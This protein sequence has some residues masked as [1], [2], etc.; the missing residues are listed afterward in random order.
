MIADLRF[1]FRMLAKNPGFAFVCVLT[2]A[3]G[4]GSATVVFSAIKTMLLNPLPMVR[5]QSRLV[6]ISE[7]AYAR[8]HADM[9]LAYEDFVDIRN[10]MTAFE[11]VWSHSDRTIVITATQAEPERLLGNEISE[12]AFQHLGLEPLHGRT[13]TPADHVFGAP[14]VAVLGHGVWRR[15]FGGDPH[16]VG[17]TVHLNGQPTVLIGVMPKGVVYPR[18]SDI[19]VPQ[20]Q[21]PAR[22]SMR[23][24]YHLIGNAKLKPGVS[25][26]QAQAEADGIMAS[27][28]REFPLTN[29]GIGLHIQSLSRQVAGDAQYLLILLFGA[30]MFVFLISCLNVANLVLARTASRSREFALRQALGAERNRLIRQLLTES[31]L[32]AFL[33]G[34]G[35]LLVSLWGMDLVLALIP[36]ETP[37]WLRFDV[38]ASIFS[39]V[40]LLSGLSA[41][42]FGLA[43]AF[44]ATHPGL[45]HEIKEGGRTGAIATVRRSRLHHGLVVAEIA[46]AL[47][48][49]VGA[50]LMM[51][52]LLHL[53]KVD[54]GFDASRVFTFRTG[55]PVGLH[56][57][58]DEVRR[59]FSSLVE[60]LEALPGVEAASATSTLPG[61]D[62]NFSAFLLDGMTEPMRLSDAVIAYHRLVMDR[63]FET[64]KIPL[65][66]GRYFDGR[67]SPHTPRVALVDEIFAREHFGTPENAIGK[68]IRTVDQ[69]DEPLVPVEIVGV[70]GNIRHR[71]D[72]SDQKPT[73]YVT[74]SQNSVNFMSV[75]MR[76]AS[77]PVDY[78]ALAQSEVLK[79]NPDIPIYY[80]FPLDQVLLQTV[81][82]RQFF[83]HLFSLFAAIAL[84][85]ACIGIY[86][87]MSYSVNQ[88]TREI[89][90]RMALGAQPREVISMV[91]RQGIRLVALGLVSG[92]VCAAVAV[93]FFSGYLYGVSPHDPPTFVLVPIA[94]AIIAL[95]ACYLPSRRA[96]RI[97]PMVALRAE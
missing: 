69:M 15:R 33:G 30:V 3:V 72:R 36:V 88:R 37:F 21:D 89:G 1:A 45:I 95:I 70:V 29:E 55:F 61:V 77:D 34:I 75:I 57:E 60:R 39:F 7:T 17:R 86:G 26:K 59:F 24:S 12:G 64:M 96:T 25:L 73:C 43:P 52:S 11:G 23:G 76:T 66:A 93:R 62:M 54:P 19:W 32:L 2:L 83:S 18:A 91:L 44:R 71:L 58:K 65:L 47:V 28:A 92:L 78:A 63:Y 74:H 85:L 56:P 4:I 20:R 68:R 87:V 82:T 16:V 13:F 22:G 94:L 79:L 81:W 14:H 38:D 42:I 97:E 41:S 50:G 31:L 53:Q 5:D 27:L 90:V 48:L 84:F 10:R 40:L 51:R 80:A 9:G 8:G 6:H 46:I 67:D 35:G 49:L